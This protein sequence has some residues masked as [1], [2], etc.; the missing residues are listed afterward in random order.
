METNTVYIAL[1]SN[2]GD[3][4]DNLRK[5]LDEISG[6][7]EIKQKSK[8]I[9][10]EPEGY[11]EQNFFLNMVIA[12]Q[13]NLT[14][15]ELLEKLQETEQKMGRIRKIKNGPRTID[16]DILFFN[17]ETIKTPDLEIPH[18]RLHKRVF[19]LNP[20]NEVAP[21]IIHP[22]LKKSI[23]TLKNELGKN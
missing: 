1:G 12:V 18:P 9:E 2:L 13:T 7:A 22:I 19:V 8:I 14:A 3:R 23:K 11:K 4:E 6:F 10:T 15:F 21:E 5:A 17:D 20:M 16:L